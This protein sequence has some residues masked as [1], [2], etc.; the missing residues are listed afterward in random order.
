MTSRTFAAVVF[1]AQGV[2]T[3]TVV[4][5]AVIVAVGGITMSIVA[6]VVVA[7]IIIAVV[8]LAVSN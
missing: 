6:V 4:D 5:L 8:I 7:V 2:N 1:E 3:F